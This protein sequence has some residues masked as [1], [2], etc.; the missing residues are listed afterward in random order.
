VT[1]KLAVCVPAELNVVEHTLELLPLE[2][3]TPDQLYEY[4]GF[5]E[6]NAL[7][8]NAELLTGRIM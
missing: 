3:E 1:D 2:Q 8:L 7:F 6:A 4:G 5:G